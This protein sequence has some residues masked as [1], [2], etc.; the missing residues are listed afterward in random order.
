MKNSLFSPLPSTLRATAAAYRRGYEYLQDRMRS[1]GREGWAQD[2]DGEI[3][4]S[5]KSPAASPLDSERGY[6][7]L[8][9]HLATNGVH[10]PNRTGV[11]TFADVGHM[12]KFD[13]R[14]GFPAVT[15]KKL[16]FGAVKGEL[17]GFFRGYDNAADFRALGCKVWDQN[18]NETPSWVNNPAR[19][20][21]DDLGRIYGVQW[22]KWRDTQVT[23]TPEDFQRLGNS[24]KYRLVFGNPQTGEAVFEREINQLEEALRAL[25]TNPFDRR[26]IVTGWRPD[27]IESQALPACHTTY[28]WVAMPDGTLHATMLMRSVDSFLGAPFNIASTSL[29]LGIMARLCGMTPGT[30]TIFTSDTHVYENHLDAVK[31]QLTRTVLPPPQLHLSERIQRVTRVEDIPGVFARIEPS[32]ISLV[33]YEHQGAIKA[34]MAA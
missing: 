14:Q 32:D 34:P 9:E 5:I 26:I 12:L 11:G 6:L 31:E 3:E 17:L 25:I 22:T 29:F 28:Q 23:K 10:K 1:L 7:G 33:G 30:V 8:L 13:L 24:S 2:C 15:T 21:H 16:A 20:G 19:K 27:E 4:A 18:A